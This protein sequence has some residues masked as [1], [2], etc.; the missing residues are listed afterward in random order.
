MFEEYGYERTTVRDIAAAAHVTERTFHRYFPSKEDLVLADVRGLLPLLQE[1]IRARPAGEPPLA[2]VLQGL[3]ALSREPDGA[4]LAALYGGPPARFA[5]R[6]S[7][8]VLT[9]LLDFEDGI[10]AVLAER[11]AASPPAGDPQRALR[12]A[13]LARAAVGA[14]RSAL[15]AHTGPGDGGARPEVLG[16]LLRTAFAALEG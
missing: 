8:P 14:V 5:A 4:G 7:R 11:M 2:A 6:V 10:A 9:V 1:E 3:L 12:A 16:D 15:I 13:V